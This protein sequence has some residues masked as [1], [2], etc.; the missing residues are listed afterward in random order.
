MID[1]APVRRKETAL[2]DIAEGL[3]RD[4]LASLAG[5]MCDVFLELIAGADDSDVTFVPEDPAANDTFAATAE[6]VN[7]PWTLGHVIVHWTASSEESAALALT[8]ARGV[9]VTG[10]SR[11]EVPWEQVTEAA[12]LRERIEE[13]RRMQLAMLEAWPDKPD[14]DKTYSPRE[15]ARPAN[16]VVRFLGGL[17]HADAHRDQVRDVLAQA[18]AARSAPSA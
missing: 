5:E 2:E 12:F 6:E 17:N 14:L 13:S 7:M 8:L 18:K 11:Y 10:R 9:D 4:D 1:F 15:G 16:A 3:T